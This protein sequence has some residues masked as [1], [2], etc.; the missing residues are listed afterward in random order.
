MK[1]FAYVVIVLMGIVTALVVGKSFL[2]PLIFAIIMWYIIKSVRELLNRIPMV[3]KMP[4]MVRT[5]FSIVLLFL[6]ILLFSQL[7]VQSIQSL[8][9]SKELY[10]TNFNTLLASTSSSIS[11]YTGFNISNYIRHFLKE[12][13]FSAILQQ[14]LASLSSIFSQLLLML[15]Y[16]LFIALED[17][18]FS[19]KV[20][21]MYPDG[22]QYKKVSSILFKINKSVSSY[23]VLKSAVSF[24]TAFLSYLIFLSFGLEGAVFWAFVIFLFNY[25]PNVGSIIATFFPALF[26]IMQFGE[27]SVGIYL[28]LII[29]GVQ[30]FVGNVIEPKVMGNS[31]NISPLVVLFSL[32]F[33]GA[34]WGISGMVLSVPVTVVMIIVMS[35][36]SSTRPFAILMSEKGTV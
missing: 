18:I 14:I 13:D 36:F 6:F 17:S 31:L 16:V 10:A 15:F 29:G 1:Q 11:D 3:K 2:T 19:K 4:E 30:L 21:L 20:R 24:S 26:G 33:W 25:V 7:L 35:E 34:I 5:F 8:A 27:I 32:T 23:L 22:V 9:E 28:L 12:F